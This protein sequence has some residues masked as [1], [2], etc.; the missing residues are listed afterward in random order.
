MNKNILVTISIIVAC[1]SSVLAQQLA[2]DTIVLLNSEEIYGKVTDTT[3]NLIKYQYVDKKQKQFES[4]F[5]KERVFS[6][7]Y[8]TGGE[9]VIY[10][11]DTLNEEEF[12]VKDMRFFIK[13][14]QDANEHFNS[15]KSFYG[16]IGMGILGS[17][18]V[19]PF[20]ILSPIVPGVYSVVNGSRWMK[21]KKMKG[22]K[23]EDL[24]K[25]T[26]LMGYTRVARNKRIQSSLKGSAI[27]LV[28]GVTTMYILYKE[29]IK[30][31]LFD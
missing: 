11:P 4:S 23:P 22:S 2:L 10:S 20:I 18:I 21:I 9:S 5:E 29:N 6:I 14:Q 31:G 27:G 30:V 16:G 28:V 12:T 19:T 1:L 13:G 8:S 24:T 7:K 25:D 17:Y 3:K 26:Y 15:K